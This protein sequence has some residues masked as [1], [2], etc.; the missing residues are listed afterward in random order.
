M[1]YKVQPLLYIEFN[2]QEL[3]F[4]LQQFF[5]ILDQTEKKLAD[6]EFKCAKVAA[7]KLSGLGFLSRAEF[8]S[9]A[10]F[11]NGSHWCHIVLSADNC[12]PLCLSVLE[13][14]GV[15]QS[16]FIGGVFETDVFASIQI[17]TGWENAS[18][19]WS[20]A[21]VNN[22]RL[23]STVVFNVYEAMVHLFILASLRQSTV[24]SLEHVVSVSS[25]DSTTIAVT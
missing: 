6:Q 3:S 18:V 15:C 12:L 9:I 14:L 16:G 13:W 5:I 11:F 22:F 7:S 21:A 24:W 2:L 1:V 25:L 20:Q 8:R 17:L 19:V 23:K 10:V 4:S